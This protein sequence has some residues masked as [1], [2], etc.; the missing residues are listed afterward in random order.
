VIRQ[1]CSQALHI[2]DRF[3]IVAKMNK[4]LDEFRVCAPEQMYGP[5]PCRKRK[6]RVAGWSA[7]MYTAFV[8]E[9]LLAMMECAALSS[10]LN[11]QSCEDFF[12]P[13]VW[14]APGLTVEPSHCSPADLAGNHNSVVA[15]G[16]RMWK[17]RM[18][19]PSLA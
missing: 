19:F 15:A 3:H 7:Q 17:S 6:V 18:R 16:L 5:P 9:F 11:S 14:R 13:Q 1:K 2:L 10:F 4:A 12:T 8:G